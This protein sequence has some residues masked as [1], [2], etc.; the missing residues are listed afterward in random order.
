MPDPFTDLRADDVPVPPDPYFAARLRHRIE[1]VLNLPKGVVPVTRKEAH[2]SGTPRSAAIPYLAVRDARRAIEWYVDVF[3]A[4]LVDDPIVMPDGRV[5]H[6]ALTIGG[7]TAYLADEHPEIGVVAPSGGASVSLMLAVA[8]ADRVRARALRA[9]ATADREPY[10]GYGQR[11]AWI[12]DPF[13]H[14]WG[15]QSPLRAAPHRHGDIAYVSVQ[16]PDVARA[17]RFHRAVLGWDVDD[18]HVPGQRPAIGFWTVVGYPT[19]FC[20]YAVDDIE[21]ARQQV[22]AL[23]GTA[24][25]IDHAPHGVTSECIDD[26]GTRFA[27][28]QIEPTP[29]EPR[30]DLVYVTF[31]VPDADATRAFYGGMLGWTFAPGS[32]PDGWQVENVTP[33]AG[34]SGGHERATTIPMWRVP[35]IAEAVGRVRAAGG[36]ATDPARQPYGV[37]SECVDD[38]GMRFYLGE[39]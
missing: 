25:P 1:R 8:D 10:D 23:G 31:E 15:L 29:A 22:R 11:N 35:D 3:D 27:L 33:L 38:Q 13:G 19:L 6:A 16:T 7:G 26:Q 4:V 9:G 34:I 32:V 20:C 39:L 14:R 12:V 28:W 17:V 5:G 30:H 18:R 36:T 37:T 24:G 21:T 2:T